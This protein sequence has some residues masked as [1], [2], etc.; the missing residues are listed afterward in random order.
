MFEKENF[1]IVT[2]ALSLVILAIFLFTYSNLDFYQ[3]IFGFIPASPKIYT[4]VTYTFI[5]ADIIHLLGNLLMLIIVGLILENTLG[6]FVFLSIYIASGNIAVIF[7]II[8]RILLGVSFN[9]PFIGASGSIFGLIAVAALIKPMEKIPTIIVLLAFIP[10]AQL[11]FTLPIFFD[12]MFL[13]VLGALAVTV[14]LIFSS[15]IPHYLPVAVAITF[16]LISWLAMISLRL[17]TTVSNI[18]HLGGVLGGIVS[19]FLFAKKKQ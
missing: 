11:L 4:F 16:Y 12:T 19:F 13:I 2:F 17:P 1:P 3:R 8:Q 6:R 5:H 7:D 10:L 14:I 15:F 9:I 18:G